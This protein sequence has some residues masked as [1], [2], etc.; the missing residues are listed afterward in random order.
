MVDDNMDSM[1]SSPMDYIHL[2][3]QKVTA[4]VDD[5][6]RDLDDKLKEVDIKN[7]QLDSRMR[8]IEG[9]IPKLEKEFQDFLGSTME[10]KDLIGIREHEFSSAMNDAF[11]QNLKSEFKE[12]ALRSES[13]IKSEFKDFANEQESAMVQN[14]KSDFQDFVQKEQ[15]EI[16]QNA[17]SDFRNFQDLIKQKTSNMAQNAK[18]DFQAGHA[19]KEESD[20]VQ[21]AKGDVQDLIKKEMARMKGNPVQI[22]NILS[23]CTKHTGPPSE[24][25]TAGSPSDR[26]KAVAKKEGSNEDQ[27]WSLWG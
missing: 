27:F 1:Y 15:S 26:K 24:S 7:R 10:F 6:M 2:V 9:I 17:Q 4:M 3:L 5:K 8:D 14:A 25:T 21:N 16:V 18:S 20:I 13:E 12:F 11:V 19:K 22:E 23:V